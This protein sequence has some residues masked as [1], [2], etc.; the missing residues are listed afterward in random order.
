MDRNNL[1]SIVQHLVSLLAKPD[2]ALSA[3]RT[4]TEALTNAVAATRDTPPVT[5]PTQ[6]SVSYRTVL[7]QRI[8]NLCGDDLYARVEDF[9]WYVSVLIDLAY[10]A[11]APVGALIRDQLVDIAV[12]VQ[13]VRRYAVQVCMRLLED[14]NFSSESGGTEA[15]GTGCQEVLWAAAWICGEYSE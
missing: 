15:E 6:S 4:A 10:V 3:T 2:S 9:E 1:Q 5:S 11:R 8:L 12:R 7:A 13:Q 14:E